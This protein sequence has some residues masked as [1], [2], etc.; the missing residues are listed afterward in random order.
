MPSMMPSAPRMTSFAISVSPTQRKTTSAF[1]ATSFGVAQNLAF[2]GVGKFLG[3]GGGVGPDGDFVSGA[4]EVAGHG[5]AHEA[6]SEK[7]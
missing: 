3:F 1:S 7:S 4:E 6:E 5:V 2:L